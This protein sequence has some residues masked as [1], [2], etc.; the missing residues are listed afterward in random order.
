MRG[1]F[2]YEPD[3]L[4]AETLDEL[5]VLAIEHR[6]EVAMAHEQKEI[7]D[8]NI[9]IARSNYFPRVIFQTDLSYLGM[10]DDLKFGRPDFSKGITSSFTLQIPIFSGF[11]YSK[12]AEKAEL[13]FNSATE[14]E[15]QM[16][17]AINAEVEIARN[18]F[19]EAE[20]KY[21]SAMKTVELGTEALR[22]A[23]VMYEEGA[24]T[25]LDVLTSQLALTRA[26]VNHANAIFEYQIARY[27][28]RK[29]I[30]TLNGVL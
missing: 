21:R 11:E 12:Q 10:R 13:D 19:R 3:D 4:S 6:H 27:Q 22:L 1:G 23:N 8:Y 28:L 17:N 18:R 9:T 29:A 24:N 14:N 20:E 2:Q 5:Q 15:R 7:A 25:Q 26:Q 30:G 16:L